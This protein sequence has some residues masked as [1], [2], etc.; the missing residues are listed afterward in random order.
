MKSIPELPD[1]KKF[2]KVFILP[3]FCKPGNHHYMVKYKDTEE[4]RQAQLLKTIRK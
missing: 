3:I 2:D 4:P 1:V